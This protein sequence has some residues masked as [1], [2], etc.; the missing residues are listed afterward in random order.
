MTEVVHDIV[1]AVG[2]GAWASLIVLSIHPTWG[3]E[4]GMWLRG[5]DRE[6][7]RDRRVQEL[8]DSV[9]EAEQESSHLGQNVDKH[10]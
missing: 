6:N 8:L 2:L 5:L 10:V 7:D 9:P 1:F 3:A 4:F